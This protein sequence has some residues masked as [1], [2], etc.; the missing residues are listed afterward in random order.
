MKG[1]QKLTA[2]QI[3]QVS[4]F[5]SQHIIAQ[6][7]K[8]LGR[9]FPF[10]SADIQALKLGVQCPHFAATSASTILS[11][12]RDNREKRAMTFAEPADFIAFLI[13]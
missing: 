1:I 2:Q 9:C 7:D 11:F 12:Q 8:F 5:V 10:G 6:R 4:G 3:V 13:Y